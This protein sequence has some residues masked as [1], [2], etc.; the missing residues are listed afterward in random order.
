VL[1]ALQQVQPAK[2]SDLHAAL[3]GIPVNTLKKDV[4]YL[5]EQGRIEKIGQKR[6]TFYLLPGDN[7]EEAP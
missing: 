5:V 4:K 1:T 7:T 3:E 2:I 6:G